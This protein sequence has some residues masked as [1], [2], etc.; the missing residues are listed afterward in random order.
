MLIL[1]TFRNGSR[2]SLYFHETERRKQLEQT[3]IQSV[4]PEWNIS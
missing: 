2:I 3:L 4:R 1:S